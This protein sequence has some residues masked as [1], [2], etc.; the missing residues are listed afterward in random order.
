M[1]PANRTDLFFQM[2]AD[3]KLGD[4]YTVFAKAAEVHADTPLQGAE[5]TLHENP[6]QNERTSAP[7]DIIIGYVVAADTDFK[8]DEIFYKMAG[9]NA[10]AG[11]PLSEIVTIDCRQIIQQNGSLH[12]LTM[13][14]PQG[15]EFH[16]PTTG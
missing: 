7:T 1:G 4:V 15:V 2:P 11:L 16:A 8:E 14:F 10:E 9:F 5:Q 3:A 6:E 13:Q 12:C